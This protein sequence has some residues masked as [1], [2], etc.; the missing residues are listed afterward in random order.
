[1]VVDA[2]S[3]TVVACDVGDDECGG[4]AISMSAAMMVEGQ[5][6]VRGALL[7]CTTFFAVYCNLI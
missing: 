2:T 7:Y 5:F 4:N 3:A 1:M 6:R